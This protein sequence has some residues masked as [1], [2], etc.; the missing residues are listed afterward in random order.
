MK[1]LAVERRCDV[2]AA[3]CKHRGDFFQCLAICY[4]QGYVVGDTRAGL[5]RPV[6][7]GAEKI[8]G[9]RSVRRSIEKAEHGTFLTALLKTQPLR[10]K[11]RCVLKAFDLNLDG[12]NPSNRSIGVMIDTVFGGLLDQTQFETIRIPEAQTLLSERP[13]VAHHIRASLD[14]AVTP[15]H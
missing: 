13:G 11:F 4:T 6:R 10:Q 1:V 15:V 5:T 12:S 9:D 14:Q 2:K 3:I 7:R 8:N